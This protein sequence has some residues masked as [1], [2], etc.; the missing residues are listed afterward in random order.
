[1]TF[2]K[3]VITNLTI[4]CFV[5]KKKNKLKII[6]FLA[7]FNLMALKGKLLSMKIMLPNSMQQFFGEEFLLKSKNVG[8]ILRRFFGKASFFY[9]KII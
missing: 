9:A 4:A 7:L 8:N 1:M 3:I 2:S 6:K 5:Y